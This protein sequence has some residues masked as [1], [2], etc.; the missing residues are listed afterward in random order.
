VAKKEYP[1]DLDDCS[2]VFLCPDPEGEWLRSE[3][4]LLAAAV[5]YQTAY[6]NDPMH[7]YHELV[8]EFGREDANRIVRW[9][10]A[11]ECNTALDVDYDPE[12]AA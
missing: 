8:S 5:G 12:G 11:I 9:I 7:T 1:G 4:E 3:R 6:R 10:E 2:A